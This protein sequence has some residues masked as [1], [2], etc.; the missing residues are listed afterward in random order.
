MKTRLNRSGE[1]CSEMQTVCIIGDADIVHKFLG[2]EHYAK[3]M[4][5]IPL[6]ELHASS[7]QHPKHDSYRWL[8]NTRRVPTQQ[9]RPH[10]AQ[11]PVRPHVPKACA[12][13]PVGTGGAAA[14]VCR[15]R[16][17]GSHRVGVQTMP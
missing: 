2:V 10:G 14:F 9:M 8:L 6:K 11:E 3:A 13:M 1:N 12:R 17:G 5:R 4:P 15:R 7:V 16:G